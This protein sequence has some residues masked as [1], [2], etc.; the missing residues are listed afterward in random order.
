M[1]NRQRRQWARRRLLDD[2]AKSASLGLDSERN[3]SAGKALGESGNISGFTHRRQAR[4]VMP[5]PGSLEDLDRFIEDALAPL[6]E[7]AE[8]IDLELAE[9][10]TRKTELRAAA[11]KIRRLISANAAKTPGP[12]SNARTARKSVASDERADELAGY[13]R[14]TFNGNEFT[15]LDFRDRDDFKPLKMSHSYVTNAINRLHSRH[16]LQL[17][18]VGVPGR[19]GGNRTKVWK[20]TEARHE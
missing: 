4:E 12:K 15:S 1:G 6:R 9:L 3:A 16:T 18:R 20:L 10:E 11:G 7:R 14:S 17:V 2:E 13:L 5:M 19:I 8:A